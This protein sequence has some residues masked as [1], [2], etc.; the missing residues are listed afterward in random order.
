MKKR[1]VDTRDKVE[2]IIGSEQQAKK[3]PL[4]RD[5]KD[6]IL[7]Q[8]IDNTV[9]QHNAILLDTGRARD[10]AARRQAGGRVRRGGRPRGAARLDPDGLPRRNSP[11]RAALAACPPPRS[12]SPRCG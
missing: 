2:R 3:R 9:I 4:T 7:Q 11:P 12:R 8:Q 6:K 1:I 5:E 10:H